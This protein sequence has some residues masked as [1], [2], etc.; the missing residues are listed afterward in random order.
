MQT[1]GDAIGAL[2]EFGEGDGGCA[3]TDDFQIGL[4]CTCAAC[5]LSV[6]PI[7]RIVKMRE[8]G[9]AK[10][11]MGSLVVGPIREQKVTRS[12]KRFD[13]HHNI[14]FSED[15]PQTSYMDRRHSA[16]IMIIASCLSR[17]PFVLTRITS[18][19]RYLQHSVPYTCW[20]SSSLI[21]GSHSSSPQPLLCS[22]SLLQ[23]WR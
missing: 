18:K 19:Q 10:F 14:S 7:E 11:R 16:V 3:I 9:P 1:V 12:L 21:D 23:G 22:A 15:S 13:P 20:L 2:G 8:L 4:A 5:Q 6:E 17:Q